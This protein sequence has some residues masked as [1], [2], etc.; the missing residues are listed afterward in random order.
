[1]PIA[2]KNRD[3]QLIR[4]AAIEQKW[5][6]QRTGKGRWMFKSPNGNGAVT[7]GGSY[8]GPHALKN[9]VARLRKLGFVSP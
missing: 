2:E 6:V 8:E 7:A 1:M 9:L 5:D 4:A 3:F